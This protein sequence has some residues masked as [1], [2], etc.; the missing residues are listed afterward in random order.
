V[1]DRTKCLWILQKKLEKF[2]GCE[3]TRRKVGTYKCY[4]WLIWSFAVALLVFSVY[5]S[6]G[7]NGDPPTIAFLLVV[8]SYLTDTLRLFVPRHEVRQEFSRDECRT[9]KT[10]PSLVSI[11]LAVRAAVLLLLFCAAA[12]RIAVMLATANEGVGISLSLDDRS[13]RVLCILTYIFAG[14][15]EGINLIENLFGV[16]SRI[17]YKRPQLTNAKLTR[18]G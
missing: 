3:A 14:L 6:L 12:V 5:V 7:K 4:S 9:G 2:F 11:R 10:I 17:R 1:S 13:F 15:S 16:E 8:G 18:E